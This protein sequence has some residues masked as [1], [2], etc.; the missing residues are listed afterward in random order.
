[1]EIAGFNQ[2]DNGLEISWADNYTSF[3][4]FIWLRD[5][6]YCEHCGDSYSSKRYIVPSEIPLEIKPASVEVS[7][8]G[9]LV[10]RWLPDNH[11]SQYGSTWLR[12]HCYDKD[13]RAARFHKPVLWNADISESLP[14]ANY[15]D[16]CKNDEVRLDV[17]RK[18]RDF[19]FVIVTNGP[20]T[21]G[22]ITSVANLIGEMGESAYTK[23]FD[24]APASNIQVLGNTTRPVPPHTDEAFR[25]SPPGINVLSCIQPANDGGD[26][27]LVDGFHLAEKLRKE[28]PDAFN[29]LTNYS[30]SFHRIHDG[31]IDQRARQRMIALDDR[32]EV[33]GV[34]IHTRASAPLDLAE[35]LVEPYYAAHH[36][37]CNLMMEPANQA[38]FKLNAGD[39]VLFDNHRVLHARSEFT[40]PNRFLQI[41]N[42]PRESFHEK[43]RLLANQL[44]YT[45]E[46]NQILASGMTY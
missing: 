18:L 23:I 19:G 2:Q 46:A 11:I 10:I 20:G 5:C 37:L 14:L 6:C 29:L 15:D 33:S 8:D 40:D 4:H 13:S 7:I 36:Y 1:M 16:A 41:C 45:D 22:S 27:I 3:F 38:R 17:C 12:Q 24:L 39:T 9:R 21:P 32:G 34:R 26:S 30:Q 28:N 42:V 25:Y 44:G 35:E 43:L 31:E